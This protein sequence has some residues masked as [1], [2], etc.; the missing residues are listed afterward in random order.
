MLLPILSTH[1]SSKSRANGHWEE[2]GKRSDCYNW[3]L[4]QS[5][6][7]STYV[8]SVYLIY[9]EK[10]LTKRQGG[11]LTGVCCRSWVSFILSMWLIAQ[12]WLWPVQQGWTRIWLVIRNF[13]SSTAQLLTSIMQGMN[14][15]SRYSIVTMIFFPP[16][17]LLWVIFNSKF[18]GQFVDVMFL[19]PSPREHRFTMYWC[20][21]VPHNLS[22]G[23]GYYP[24]RDGLCD[25]VAHSLSLSC[26][27]SDI[28]GP[29]FFPT[30]TTFVTRCH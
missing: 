21:H 30:Y 15:G 29:Y 13:S 24:N 19:Q 17:V 26:A 11:K 27:V 25:V 7:S 20:P 9:L 8:V 12:T 2:R 16:Y 5:R 18:S 22:R 6:Y 28:G 10:N 23:V 4:L 14:I 3:H 1:H